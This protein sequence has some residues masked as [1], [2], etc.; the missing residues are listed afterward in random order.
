VCTGDRIVLPTEQ[1]ARVRELFEHGHLAASQELAA[2]L[3]TRYQSVSPEW[4]AKLRILQA[5][6]AAWRGMNQEVVRVLTPTLPSSADQ[7]DHARRWSLL[8]AA[9]MHLQ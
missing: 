4:S 5:E 6:S 9:N 1:F 2:E 3:A 8:A 7:N